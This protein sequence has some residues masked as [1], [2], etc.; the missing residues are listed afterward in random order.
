MML[1]VMDV[2][3][4]LPNMILGFWAKLLISAHK[5]IAMAN[6]SGFTYLE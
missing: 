2:S 3:V 6:M 5:Q 1:A 4:G